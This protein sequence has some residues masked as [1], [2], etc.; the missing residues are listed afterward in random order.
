[1]SRALTRVTTPASAGLLAVALVGCQPTPEP[2]PTPA[3]LPPPEER[4][5]F[6]WR[7]DTVVS[8]AARPAVALLQ[9]WMY[10]YYLWNTEPAVIPNLIYDRSAAEVSESI[11]RA[12]AGPKPMAGSV[13]IHLVEIVLLEEGGEQLTVAVGL[14]EDRLDFHMIDQH[15]EPIDHER[16]ITTSRAVLAQAPDGQ[17]VVA[18]RSFHDAQDLRST[19]EAYATEP[20]RTPPTGTPG[21]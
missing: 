15:G 4:L 3:P 1:M 9:D 5:D 21:R 20:A 14:C 18:E 7:E 10:A 13:R 2:P 16:H 11:E 19:C 12:S 8:A 17:W 6:H